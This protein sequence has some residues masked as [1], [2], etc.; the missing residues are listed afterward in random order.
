V[1]SVPGEALSGLFSPVIEVSDVRRET[2]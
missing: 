1:L 2:A